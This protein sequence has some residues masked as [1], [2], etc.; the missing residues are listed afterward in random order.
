MQQE[1]GT[2]EV[3]ASKEK[4]ERWTSIR[5]KKRTVERLKQAGRKGETYDD[6]IRRLIR[7]AESHTQRESQTVTPEVSETREEAK[8]VSEIENVPKDI[9]KNLEASSRTGRK[10]ITKPMNYCFA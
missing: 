8:R 4:D 3:E 9:Q 5:V 10:R 1:G 2:A 7:I 6:I